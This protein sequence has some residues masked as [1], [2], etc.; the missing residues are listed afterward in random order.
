MALPVPSYERDSSQPCM[1]SYLH[2]CTGAILTDYENNLSQEVR[3]TQREREMSVCVCERARAHLH[4]GTHVCVC[5]CAQAHVVADGS[6]V[7]Y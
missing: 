3:H 6:I 7:C 1:L 5:V 4:T 2:D